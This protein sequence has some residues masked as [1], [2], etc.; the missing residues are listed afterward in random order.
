[1]RAT[2][3]GQKSTDKRRHPECIYSLVISALICRLRTNTATRHVLLL[4]LLH[5]TTAAT[6]ALTSSCPE[7][8]GWPVYFIFFS[9]SLGV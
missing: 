3:L 8:E 5:Y 2:R 9:L 6:T 4:L 1:M 7:P